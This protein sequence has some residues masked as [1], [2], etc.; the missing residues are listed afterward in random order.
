VVV[1]LTSVVTLQGMDRAVELG[2]D[3]GKEVCESGE[4]VRL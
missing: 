1:G 3:P 2:G 4:S